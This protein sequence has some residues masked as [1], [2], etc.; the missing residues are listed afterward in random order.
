M[1]NRHRGRVW[2]EGSD[3]P[4]DRSCRAYVDKG[5]AAVAGNSQAE[6]ISTSLD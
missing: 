1:C 3:A 6:R 2:A 5:S 4:G